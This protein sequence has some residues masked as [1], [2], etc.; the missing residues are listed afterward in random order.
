MPAAPEK[1]QYDNLEKICGKIHISA[2]LSLI[3][4]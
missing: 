2:S 4:L 3:P 1:F